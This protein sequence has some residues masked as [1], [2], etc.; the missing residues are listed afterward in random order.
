M[1]GIAGKWGIDMKRF[2]SIFIHPTAGWLYFAAMFGIL[3]AVWV[4]LARDV[5]D[6]FSGLPDFMMGNETRDAV[7]TDSDTWVFQIFFGRPYLALFVGGIFGTLLY[8]WQ[9]RFQPEIFFDAAIRLEQE[10]SEGR[11]VRTPLIQSGLPRASMLLLMIFIGI[12]L[13]LPLV[14]G[15]SIRVSVYTA[16]A[17]NFVFWSQEWRHIWDSVMQRAEAGYIK[18][19]TQKDI[20][21]VVLKRYAVTA[22][23]AVLAVSLVAYMAYKTR[24]ILTL[25]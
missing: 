15:Y 18:N 19:V 10:L 4:L 14:F 21:R 22:V 16:V 1:Q 11:P 2:V 17:V 23:A 7:K 12:F 5:N 8:Y 13:L 6:M 9:R 24:E 20:R 25:P 3:A